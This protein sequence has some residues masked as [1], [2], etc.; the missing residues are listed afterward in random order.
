M[1]IMPTVLSM[2]EISPPPL[3]DGQVP[4][5][6]RTLYEPADDSLRLDE[7]YPDAPIAWQIFNGRAVQ[8][9]RWKAVYLQ[10]P[11]GPAS[12][13]LF[14]LAADPH[15]TNDLSAAFPDQ[16]ADMIAAWDAAMAER[17]WISMPIPV[18]KLFLPPRRADM[19][20]AP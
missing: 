3:G 13:Q 17:G 7:A 16:L 9:G 12:W 15:E 14:D 11:V 18:L 2:L 8:H 4:T 20:V 5:L 10:D 6:G 1:D 19:S